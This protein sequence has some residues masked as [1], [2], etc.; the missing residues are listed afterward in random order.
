MYQNISILLASKHHKEEAIRQPFLESFGAEIK[1]TNDFDT[2]VYGTFSGEIKRVGTPYETVVTKALDAMARYNCDYVIANEGSFGPHP[3]NFFIPADLELM[4]FIDRVKNITIVESELSTDTN[5]CQLDI[6]HNQ[7]YSEFLEKI[8]FGTHGL[9]VKDIDHDNVIAK[10]IKELPQLQ[11]ILNESFQSCE[12]IR[13]ETDMRAMMNPT[14]MKVINSLA[15][16]LIIRMKSTCVKCGV[17][18]FGKTSVQ[19]RLKC[20]HCHS[21]TE[22]YEHKVLSCI[23][24]EHKVV[25]RRDD[26]LTRASQVNCPSCNP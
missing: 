10:G 13:L 11:E 2:D 18:G 3:Y 6:T 9:I 26:G 25:Y 15:K 1:V 5:F 14:R 19:G 17:P 22:L 12:K 20:E 16:K 4:V 7:A 23:E 21:E 8:Q 24:C